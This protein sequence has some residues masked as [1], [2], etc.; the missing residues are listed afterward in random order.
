MTLTGAMLLLSLLASGLCLA[1]I[2]LHILGKTAEQ[3]KDRRSA[4]LLRYL[5][6]ICALFGVI[7]WIC[8]GTLLFAAIAQAKR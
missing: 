7:G 4:D 8:A 5:S 2:T 3:R 1:A 6:R